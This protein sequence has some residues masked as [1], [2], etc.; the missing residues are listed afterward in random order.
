MR[1]SR[2]GW[3]TGGLRLSAS[4]YWRAGRLPRAGRVILLAIVGAIVLVEVVLLVTD[5][6]VAPLT[7][8]LFQI[9]LTVAFALFALDAR[10][11]GSVLLLAVLAAI[12]VDGVDEALLAAAGA[13]GFVVGA[14]SGGF[15][16]AYV[17]VLVAATS[18]FEFVGVEDRSTGST[19]LLMLIALVSFLI[20]FFLRAYDQRNR[21][22][23]RALDRTQEEIDRAQ[24]AERE[25][26]ADELHDFIGHELTIIAMH[27]RVLQT[28]DDPVVRDTALAAIGEASGQ[29]LADVRRVLQVMHASRPRTAADEAHAA[30]RWLAPTIVDIERELAGL[31]I[32]VTVTGVDDVAGQLSASVDNT[33]AGFAREAGTN[34]VKH[35]ST[36]DSVRIALACHGADVRM[37]VANRLRGA[38]G[39]LVVPKGGYGLARMRERATLLGGV[40][41]AGPQ[42][43]GWV[44][45]VTLPRR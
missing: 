14:A 10:V 24:Q 17:V 27:V 29:A 44:V 16:I 45:D 26:I 12:W 25:R 15:V 2:S 34:I 38:P 11:A 19:A 31:G 32:D 8:Q 36:T 33:L 39:R 5:P 37:S 7:R 18:L 43:D 4:D 9:A 20:G 6:I 35:A 21:Q 28:S 42:D 40:L 23:R 30:R 3:T 41:T 13:T 1:T 22:L